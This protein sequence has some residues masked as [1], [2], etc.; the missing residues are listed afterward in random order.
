MGFAENGHFVGA[1][2]FKDRL[3]EIHDQEKYNVL[4]IRRAVNWMFAYVC[5][6]FPL[7]LYYCTIAITYDYN[8]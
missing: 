2:R 3:I 4:L 6:Y 7:K 8:L 5:F 1:I